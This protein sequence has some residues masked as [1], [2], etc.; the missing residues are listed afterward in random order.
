[1]KYDYPDQS[2]L[3]KTILAGV[4]AGIA[5]T[6]FNLGYDFMFRSFTHFAPAQIINVATIIFA[7]ML[8]FTV[9]GLIYFFLSK[10]LKKGE[11]LYM[12]LFAVAT[13]WCS[14]MSM[15]TNRSADPLVTANF[16]LLLLGI[17]LISGALATLFIPYLMKHQ[18]LFLDEQ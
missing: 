11:I 5:G 17:V 1:M 12:V 7:S 8:F 3:S 9:A 10:F 18:T 4:F 14:T 6:L 16:R 13:Y 2:F 15:H